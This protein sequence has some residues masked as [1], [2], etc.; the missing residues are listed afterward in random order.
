MQDGRITKMAL[1]KVTVKSKNRHVETGVKRPSL[2][3][4]EP[5][6][7]AVSAMPSSDGASF[8]ELALAI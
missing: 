6:R 8:A 4:A 3:T 7:G 1:E 5:I 2:Q